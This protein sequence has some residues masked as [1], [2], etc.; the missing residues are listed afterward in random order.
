M[1]GNL[2][3]TVKILRENPDFQGK[4]KLLKN[5]EQW[6]YFQYS[7]FTWGDLCNLD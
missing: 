5:P 1:V 6:K 7:I 3:N 4:R 2:F